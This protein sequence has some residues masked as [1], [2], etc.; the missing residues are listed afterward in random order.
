MRITRHLE[1]GVR[2]VGKEAVL[3]LLAAGWYLVFVLIVDDFLRF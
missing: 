3:A 2:T 1:P